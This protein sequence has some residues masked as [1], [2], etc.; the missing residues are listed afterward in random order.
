MLLLI[1][2]I[3]RVLSTGGGGGGGGAS[4]PYTPASPPNRLGKL[5]I[6]DSYGALRHNFGNSSSELP[7]KVKILDRTL[8]L[9]VADLMFI[10]FSD[11]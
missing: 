6:Y 3:F 5:Y 7:P 8:I 1:V 9:V 2:G 4:S 10:P 11:I